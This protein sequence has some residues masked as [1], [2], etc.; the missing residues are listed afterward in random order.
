MDENVWEP[1]SSKVTQPE[2]TE[3]QVQAA[4]WKVTIFGDIFPCKLKKKKK[5]K[6]DFVESSL[7]SG[8][9]LGGNVLVFCL[10]GISLPYN[11]NEVNNSLDMFDRSDE[12]QKCQ[13]L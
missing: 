10:D 7:P 1:G 2:S 6:K 5:K 8:K 3:R 13:L 4:Q 11:Y 12:I 9:Y